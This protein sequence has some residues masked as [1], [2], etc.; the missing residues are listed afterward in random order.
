MIANA[1]RD[2]S[3][4]G[5]A[6]EGDRRGFGLAARR[7]YRIAVCLFAQVSNAIEALGYL[8]ACGLSPSDVVALVASL[9]VGEAVSRSV[10]ALRPPVFLRLGPPDM[11]S[12]VHMS[13]PASHAARKVGS[14]CGWAAPATIETLGAE[15]SRGHLALL[16]YGLRPFVHM[17]VA[18]MLVEVPVLRLEVHDIPAPGM[19]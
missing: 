4:M 5:C 17:L 8:H 7:S 2:R 9:D 16:I 6:H 14:L 1:L 19:H 12:W 10:V 18:N 15:L 11:A 3:V 13:A